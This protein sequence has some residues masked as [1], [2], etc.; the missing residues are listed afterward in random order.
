MCSNALQSIDEKINI[1]TRDIL[2]N[3]RHVSDDDHKVD[4][5]NQFRPF[6]Y[7]FDQTDKFGNSIQKDYRRLNGNHKK[8]RRLY[9]EEIS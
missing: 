8:I 4:D 1:C 6:P 3:D 5:R 7:D 2:N 9:L